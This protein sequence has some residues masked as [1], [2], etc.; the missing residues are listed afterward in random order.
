MLLKSRI[1]ISFVDGALSAQC[2]TMVSF[3]ND[4]VRLFIFAMEYDHKYILHTFQ[5]WMCISLPNSML[6]S[7]EFEH[8][9]HWM[10]VFLCT[11][12]HPETHMDALKPYNSKSVIHTFIGYSEQNHR[13]RPLCVAL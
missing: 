4:F 2:R 6:I 1:I 8:F 13:K 3:Y 5:S 11:G 7:Y 10:L 9:Y 12:G